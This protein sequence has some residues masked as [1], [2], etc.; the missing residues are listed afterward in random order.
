MSPTLVV[1]RWSGRADPAA[2]QALGRATGAGLSVFGSLVKSGADSVRLTASVLDVASGRVLGEIELRDHADRLDRIADSLT[3]GV[4]RE[5][6]RSR[7]IGAVRSTALGSTSLPALKAFLQGEQFMRRSSW[8]SALANYQRAIDLDSTFTLALSHA[9]QAAGWQH[10]GSDRLSTDYKLRAGRLN[11]GLAPRESL[12][13]HAESLT[14]VVFTGPQQLAGGW[15]GHGRRLLATLNDAVAQYPGD[16]ELWYLLG[17]ARFHTA[18]PGLATRREAL[19]AFNRAIELDSAF[20]PAYIHAID[21]ALLLDGQAAGRRY[22]AAFLAF[23]PEGR[24][25][26][27]TQLTAALLG[28]G[29][30]AAEVSRLLDS[31]P[32]NVV[33]VALGSTLRWPDSA[34]TAVHVARR[35]RELWLKPGA[36][37]TDSLQGNTPLV[38]ALAFRGHAS[39]ALKVLGHGSIPPLY[40]ELALLGAVP[41]ES[42]AVVFT[43]WFSPTNREGQATW[44]ALPWFAAQHDTAAITAYGTRIDQARAHL[45]PNVPAIAK[46]VLGYVVLATHAYAALARGDSAEALRRFTALP[47]SACFQSCPMDNIIEAQLLAAAGRN[48]EAAALLDRDARNGGP[49]LPSE[50][51][52]ALERGRI[53]ER[54]GERDEAIAAYAQVAATWAHADTVLKSFVD[55]ARTALTRLGAEGKR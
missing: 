42:A 29:I 41:A 32:R 24:Y 51:L 52:R 19:D 49:L 44:T 47:D 18:Q 25:A 3:V 54:L 14:A 23:D 46:E 31:A 21:L 30:G 10:S 5:L 1:R 27:S 40:A 26:A 15:Y 48:R 17:D 45:P 11:H 53:H 6:G 16:P 43:Q 34:E 37:L 12:M 50:T 39:E 13:I 22:A 2:A 4:L 38:L 33:S 36:T 55:E 9:G 7:A 20:T 28:P 35:L 8:D